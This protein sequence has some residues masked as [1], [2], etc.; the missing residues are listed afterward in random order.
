VFDLLADD[1]K[2]KQRKSTYE[3]LKRVDKHLRP[4]FG[5]MKACEIGTTTFHNFI[6]RRCGRSRRRRRS[7]KSCHGC[8]RRA[9]KLGARHQPPLVLQVPEMFDT[10]PVDNARGTLD[11]DQYRVIRDALPLYARIA[12][13][14]GY[15]TGSPKGEITSILVNWVD[16]KAGRFN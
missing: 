9:M 8:V 14:I 7:T 6:Q 10:L 1:Y 12:L 4:Y 2:F 3:C 15:H 5:A 16:L 13:V 11:N